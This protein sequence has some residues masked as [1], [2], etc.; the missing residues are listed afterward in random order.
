MNKRKICIISFEANSDCLG[1]LNTNI[2]SSFYQICSKNSVNDT[3]F[4]EP[5]KNEY[6][7]IYR[8]DVVYKYQTDYFPYLNLKSTY[9]EGTVYSTNINNFVSY[10]YLIMVI[11]GT[12]FQEELSE[13]IIKVLQRKCSRVINPYMSQY[14]DK[15]QGYIMPVMF[16]ITKSET[17]RNKFDNND[18]TNIISEAFNSI[19]NENVWRYIMCLSSEFQS[20]ANIPIMIGIDKA[21]NLTT[22]AMKN[23]LDSSTRYLNEQI[24]DQQGL[25]DMHNERILKFLSKQEAENAKNKIKQLKLKIHDEE[26]E[27]AK[28]DIWE[29][30]KYFKSALARKL[31]NN[32]DI[33]VFG[34]NNELQ[35]PIID[36]E[37]NKAVDDNDIISLTAYCV[38]LLILGIIGIWLP[39]VSCTILVLIQLWYLIFESKLRRNLLACMTHFIVFYKFSL[40]G[41]S[42]FLMKISFILSAI[43]LIYKIYKLFLKG[44]NKNG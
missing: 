1:L 22:S 40:S 21:F 30:D 19:F 32:Q 27:Y 17:F 39:A 41:Y 6:D 7:L 42:D 10:D 8:D 28:N 43:G 9:N 34:F 23:A 31:K 4:S 35:Y 24:G 5:F 38:I 36:G 18:I 16:V 20:G 44:E 13:Q 29:Q 25:I 12:F 14:S 3:I 11:D 33:L 15:H 26:Q 2:D 37:E